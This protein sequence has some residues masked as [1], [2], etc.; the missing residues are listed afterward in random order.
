MAL[1]LIS[2]LRRGVHP[3]LFVK[4]DFEIAVEQQTKAHDRTFMGVPDSKCQDSHVHKTNYICMVSLYSTISIS[5]KTIELNRV[6]IY[7]QNQ[8]RIVF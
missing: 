3:D 1:N 8:R 2:I 7:F 4:L 5:F 6:L